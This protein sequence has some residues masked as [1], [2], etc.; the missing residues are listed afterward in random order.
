V[1]VVLGVDGCAGS[2]AVAVGADRPDARAPELHL[3]GTPEDV[4]ALARAA[5]A[6]VVC[7]DLPLGLAPSG[8]RAADALARARLRG[9]GGSASRVFGTPPRPLVE[10]A[11]HLD[12]AGV[13]ALA[14]PGARPSAQAYALLAH[15][16][17]WDRTA[18]ALAAAGDGPRLVEAHPEVSLAAAAGRVLARK[19]SARGVGERLAVLGGVLG[20]GTDALVAALAQAPPGVAPDD[21]LDAA[22][23]VW[24]A[25]RVAAGTAETLPADPPR[26]DAGLLMAVHV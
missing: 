12:H 24:T 3:V 1:A 16:R 9:P 10:A 26:D 22:A 17:A 25:R 4:L 21:A 13:V 8:P 15:V 6:S 20:C 11:E 7:L 14:E 5:G 23:L 2:W 18:R 19:R